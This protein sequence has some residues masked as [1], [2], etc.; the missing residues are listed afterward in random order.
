MMYDG[1]R[2]GRRDGDVLLAMRYTLRYN[3]DALSF[4]CVKN[5]GIIAHCILVNEKIILSVN[6]YTKKKKE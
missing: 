6:G 4:R 3:V 2:G 5:Y 1:G